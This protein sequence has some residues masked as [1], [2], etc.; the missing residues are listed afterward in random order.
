MDSAVP[1]LERRDLPGLDHARAAAAYGG[2]CVTR[3]S[4]V[5]NSCGPFL[6][7][8][9][10]PPSILH[11]HGLYLVHGSNRTHV[12]H[13]LLGTADKTQR[14]L[15]LARR[16]FL[17]IDDGPI[18]DAFLANLKA[19][20]FDPNT[21]TFNPLRAIDY[22][23][24]RL[25]AETIYG[26][27]PQGQDTLT[28]RNGKRALARMLLSGADRL[29][30]LG[31]NADPGAEEALATVADMLL[32]PVLRQVLCNPTNFSF[33]GS[34]VARLNRAGLGDFDAFVLASLLIGQHKG[35]VIV[36]DFGFYGRPLHMSLIR[37]RRLI[38]GLNFLDEVPRNLAQAL[39]SIPEKE[40]RG[41]TYEDAQ[42]LAGFAGLIRG[43]NN[44]DDF[45]ERAMQNA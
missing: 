22:P 6:F 1:F 7:A 5:Y 17:L 8:V 45:V 18:A 40:G 35:Q 15:S 16:G 29:D 38:A 39:L 36:P 34:V 20:E 14:L 24:A 28:V 9:G 32:S 33:R 44:Y 31:D 41:C 4:T 3:E 12:N 11:T 25:I 37:Q 13:L 10:G 27:Y 2:F 43:Q 26:A 21:H 19:R 30:K 42:T 23:R